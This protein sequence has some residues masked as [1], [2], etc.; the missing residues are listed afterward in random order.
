MSDPQPDVDAAL[1]DQPYAWL[2][3]LGRRSR[4]PRT[5]ELWFHLAG[6]TLW[7]LAGDGD[8]ANWVRNALTEPQVRVRLGARRFRGLAR[9]SSPGSDDDQAAREALAGK[10]QGWTEG[11][12]LS[13]WARNSFC[14]A[15]DL[16]SEDTDPPPPDP[17]WSFGER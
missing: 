14:M 7:F 2:T 5:V 12:P 1:D 17:P 4:Q 11:R 8:R 9:A 13:A 15:V 6:P 3:T 10:Y 16:V